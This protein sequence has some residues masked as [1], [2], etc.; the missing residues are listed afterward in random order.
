[1]DQMAIRKVPE[2]N[3]RLT[4]LAEEAGLIH[5]KY[6]FGHLWPAHLTP[7]QQ[8]FAELI[9]TDV[10]DIL[11]TYRLKVIFHDG[12]EYNCQHPI[13]AI[14]KHFGVNDERSKEN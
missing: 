3:N 10:V 7:E 2:M 4:K 14:E 9:L 11:S 5:G 12:I 1:M 6:S 13:H 8:K